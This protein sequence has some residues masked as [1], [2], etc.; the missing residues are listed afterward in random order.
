[1]PTHVDSTVCNCCTLVFGL[2]V[3]FGTYLLFA[4]SVLGRRL[5]GRRNLKPISQVSPARLLNNKSD[6]LGLLKA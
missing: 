1:M 6:T 5:A 2:R 4:E 3:R